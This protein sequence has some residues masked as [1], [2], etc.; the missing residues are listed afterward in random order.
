MNDEVARR[1][2]RFLP[3]GKPHRALGHR[4]ITVGLLT[5]DLT[6]DFDEAELPIQP[7]PILMT[8]QD[9]E[10]R[11]EYARPRHRG[12]HDLAP[13]TTAAMRRTYDHPAEPHHRETLAFDLNFHK[14]HSRR[15]SEPARLVSETDV[16]VLRSVAQR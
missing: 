6:I 13:Q 16:P 15:R 3:Q 11:P 5:N 1:P 14:D 4:R 8:K 2:S 10:R 9:R 7:R 12:L